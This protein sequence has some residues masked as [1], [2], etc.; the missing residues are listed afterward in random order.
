[1]DGRDSI[2]FP[3]VAELAQNKSNEVVCKYSSAKKNGELHCA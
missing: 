3:E 1:M 2:R